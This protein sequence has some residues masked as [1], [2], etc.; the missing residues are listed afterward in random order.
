MIALA[1]PFAMALKGN[2]V[3]VT[4]NFGS[5]ID[6]ALNGIDNDSSKNEYEFIPGLYETGA[7][8][9]YMEQGPMAIKDMLIKSWDKLITDGDV[10]IE[11][12]SLAVGRELADKAIEKNEYGFYF[13]IPYQTILGIRTVNIIFYEDGSMKEYFDSGDFMNEYPAGTAVYSEN[14]VTYTPSN[15]THNGMFFDS[16]RSLY[17]SGLPYNVMS[18]GDVIQLEGDLLISDDGSVTSI[19]GYDFLNASIDTPYNRGFMNQTSLTGI[20]VPATVT[21]F[22]L[23]TFENCTSLNTIALPFVGATKDITNDSYFAYI[24]ENEDNRYNPYV[25]PAS[26]Q[27]VIVFDSNELA[28]WAFWACETLTS[29]VLSEGVT[30]V[31]EGVFSQ[32]YQLNEVYLPS[33]IEFIG[34]EAFYD[35]QININYNGTIEQ[36]TNVVSNFS[37]DWASGSSYTIFCTN[38]T[39]AEDG[40]VTLNP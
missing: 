19:G 6:A 24:F 12:G 5:R 40:T 21:S 1:S 2:V 10:V 28:S 18:V 27:T 11:N 39:I 23:G 4:N 3:G 29:V 25:V 33:S 38:G 15:T 13:G 36:W 17:T 37:P 9:L 31:D 26:L 7:V 34:A 22:K 35:C 14:G 8:S 20:Y 16:G 32:C 30:Y